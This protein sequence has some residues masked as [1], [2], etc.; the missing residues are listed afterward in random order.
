[1]RRV[2][3]GELRRT[4]QTDAAIQGDADRSL[5]LPVV[6]RATAILPIG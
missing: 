2:E 4:T 5:T 3:R 1:M 6:P